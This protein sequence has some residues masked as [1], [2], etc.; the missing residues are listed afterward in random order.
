[1]RLRFSPPNIDFAACAPWSKK[2]QSCRGGKLRFERT[3]SLTS[4][5]IRLIA[6]HNLFG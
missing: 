1:M 6:R 3:K 4:V 5:N 2:A